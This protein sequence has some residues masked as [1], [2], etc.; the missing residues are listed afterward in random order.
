MWE[1]MENAKCYKKVFLNFV[2]VRILKLQFWHE[3]LKV[4]KNSQKIIILKLVKNDFQCLILIIFSGSDK[5]QKK[6]WWCLTKR[7][8]EK[9]VI[10]IGW[11]LFS[12]VHEVTCLTCEGV[13][14]YFRMAN[15][16]IKLKNKGNDRF[17][18]LYLFP[19]I[20]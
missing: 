9:T 10:F 13:L 19:I 15:S 3:H 6:T 18:S 20:I 5:S 12:S 11:E 2:R 8:F 1:N 16:E 4:P 7:F 17:W 14:K